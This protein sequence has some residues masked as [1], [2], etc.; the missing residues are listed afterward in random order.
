MTAAS[1]G[2]MPDDAGAAFDLLVEPLERVGRPDLAPVRSRERGE[3]EDLGLGVVHQRADLG[4]PGGEL[5]ADLVPG[6]VAIGVGVGLGEDGAEHRGDHVACAPWARGRAGC[7]RSGPG[8]V[9]AR[10]P[11]SSGASAATRPACWSEMTSRTPA[12]PRSL[13]AVRKPRQNT[14]SSLSPT[15]RPRISRRAVG[16]DPGGDHD[17]HGD[18]LAGARC[19]RAG[20][21]RRGRRTGTRCGPGVRVRNAPT[22]S[23]RPAQIRDTSDLEIPASTPSAST[24]SSTARV[25]TP[26][27]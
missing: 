14:S 24:R 10:R 8:S 2:K 3:G 12:R 15:S 25:D 18:H 26:C 27:T 6:C 16:G 9:G 11:G 22:T 13:S 7:G 21:W 1:L 17:G 23:S 20:R 5:V 4:E 19:A